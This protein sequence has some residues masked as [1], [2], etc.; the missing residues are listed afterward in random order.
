MLEWRG[1]A[2]TQEVPD[3]S[4]LVLG[5]GGGMVFRYFGILFCFLLA[6]CTPTSDYTSSLQGGSPPELPQQPPP[7][8]PQQPEPPSGWGV[9]SHTQNQEVRDQAVI[10]E[11]DCE[12]VNDEIGFSG[13]IQTQVSTNCFQEGEEILFSSPVLLS[14]SAGTKSI[15]VSRIVSGNE[16]DVQTLALVFAVFSLSSRAFSDGGV[17]PS[18][19]SG[20]RYPQCTG[21]NSFPQLSW[22]DAP[23]E[24]DSFALIVEDLTVPWVHL[25]LFGLSPQTSSLDEIASATP[26]SFPS[27]TVVGRNTW[28]DRGWGGPCPPSGTHR[29]RFKLY[30]LSAGGGPASPPSAP[31]TMS[32]FEAL[33]SSSILDSAELTGTFSR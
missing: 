19:F 4:G 25:N 18:R 3:L 12:D 24:T 21:S 32:S 33:Y 23:S 11:G 27:G 31:I 2:E 30:A 26:T 22:V 5:E 1:A 17:I 28:R 10:L 15:T 6:A 20:S 7:E 16:E 13:D 9:T 29:Y 14:P 8:L